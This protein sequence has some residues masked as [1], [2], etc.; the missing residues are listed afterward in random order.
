MGII[1]QHLVGPGH[2]AFGE[3]LVEAQIWATIL[4]ESSSATF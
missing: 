3:G 2:A 1:T 4:N